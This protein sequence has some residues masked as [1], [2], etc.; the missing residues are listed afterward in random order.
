[1]NSYNSSFVPVDPEDIGFV[2][3]KN[4]STMLKIAK[5]T[6]TVITYKPYNPIHSPTTPPGFTVKGS[7]CDIRAAC[8]Q[9]IDVAC[10]NRRRRWIASYEK[11][12]VE[13]IIEVCLLFV[14]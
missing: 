8:K 13:K 9:L 4:G 10:E 11:T 1:M 5:N 7:V 3:G 12:K 2:M 6:H 14:F